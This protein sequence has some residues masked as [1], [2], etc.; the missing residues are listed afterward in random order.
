MEYHNQSGMVLIPPSSDIDIMMGQ[1]TV[2][3]EFEQQ[4]SAYGVG[5]L[6]AVIVPCGGGSLLAGCATWLKD[7]PTEVWG[8][9]P[10]HGGPSLYRSLAA[11]APVETDVSTAR[12][13]VA[14]G[15]R[16]KLGTKNWET[17]REPGIISGSLPV[18]E[19]EILDA[20]AWYDQEFNQAIEPSAVVGIAASASLVQN[21]RIVKEHEDTGLVLGIIL[22]GS[23][24]SSGRFQQLIREHKDRKTL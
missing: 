10:F 20:L 8:A 19:E 24:I 14:D 12:V 17:L 2:M 9:E 11:G 1:A 23:N 13:T 15:Q 16:T 3:V 22:T 7:K 6:G 21:A 4:V 5:N 18:T